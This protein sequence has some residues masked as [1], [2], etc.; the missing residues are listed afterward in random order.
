MSAFTEERQGTARYLQALAQHWPFIAG[1]VALAIGAAILYLATADSRYDAHA[2]VLVTPVAVN[3][4]TFVGLPVIRESGEARTVLTVARLVE[5]PQVADNV[6]RQLRLRATR[7]ELFDSV[8]VDPQEQSNIVTITGES[9]SAEEAAA[10]ANAF[11]AGVISERTRVF[12]RQLRQIVTR[13]SRRL[14]DL[15]AAS[16]GEGEGRALADRLGELRGLIG[17]QD[18]TLQIASRAVSPSEPS[19]PRPLLS[20]IAAGLIGLVLGV[21]IAIAIELL[22]PL[23]IRDEDILEEH[24][25]LLARVPEPRRATW[26]CTSQA[27]RS[28]TR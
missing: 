21:G 25:V 3:D 9:A 5:T 28:Q 20:L 24:L 6:R 1:S 17:A 16:R 8:R 22:N 26:S 12:Q 13:L 11:A 4:A 27:K 2:D 7:D 19:W 18:P 23:V 15:P 14:A 10:I